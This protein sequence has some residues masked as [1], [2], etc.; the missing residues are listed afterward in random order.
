LGQTPVADV[1]T[2]LVNI[3]SHRADHVE[4]RE[5]SMFNRIVM[6]AVLAGLLAGGAMSGA[7]AQQPV[8]L[9]QQ[10]ANWAAPL[11]I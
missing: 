10:A 3:G 7:Q 2:F 5:V 6:A 8:S 1:S 4:A 11:P 9:G